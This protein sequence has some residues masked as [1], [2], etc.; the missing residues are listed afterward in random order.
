MTDAPAPA[1]A[2]ATEIT[3]EDEARYR[4]VILAISSGAFL[5]SFAM[6]FWWPFLPLFLRQLGATSDANAL[7]WVGVATTVQGAARLVSGPLWGVISDRYGRKLMLVRALYAA[8]LTT[9]IAAAA[10]APWVVVVA[11][12]MQGLF[13]GFIPAAIALTSVSVPD[14]RLNRSLGVVTGGQYLGST[15]GPAAG[16]LLAIGFGYRGAIVASAVLPALAATWIIFAVPRDHIAPR[17]PATSPVPQ[18]R[19]V[20]LSAGWLRGFSTA[21]WVAVILYFGLFA[22]NQFVRVATPV[23]LDDIVGA[24]RARGVSG[25]VFSLGGAAAVAGVTVVASRVGG[26]ASL[27][28]TLIV[29]T[30]VSAAAMPALAAGQNAWL[31]GA[32]FLVFALVN[33]ASMPATN[34]LIAATVAPARRG[35]AFGLASSAQAVAFMAGPMGAAGF[36]AVSLPAGFLFCALVFLVLAALASAGIREGE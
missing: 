27:R 25:I 17:T 32:G 12:S 36:A 15:L 24:D 18:Q 31:Y 8:T 14:S 11:L 26:R 22:V 35:T 21:F 2:P 28:Q 29:F 20:R 1:I 5:A 23:A 33:A 9:A 7:F 6:N 4:R 19:R 3:P 10:H 34:T 30:L 16:A 13:S